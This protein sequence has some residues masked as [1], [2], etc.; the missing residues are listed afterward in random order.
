M[1]FKELIKPNCALT[2]LLLDDYIQIYVDLKVTTT[3]WCDVNVPCHFFQQ[4]LLGF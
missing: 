2:Y 3:E 4:F 1:K